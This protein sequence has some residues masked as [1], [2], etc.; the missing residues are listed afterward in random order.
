MTEQ[1]VGVATV[2]PTYAMTSVV[3]MSDWRSGG[4]FD[5]SMTVRSAH[6]IKGAFDLDALRV[7]LNDLVERHDAL[8]AVLVRS[9]VEI[10]LGEGVSGSIEPEVRDIAADAADRD[11]AATAF[12]AEAAA[13]GVAAEA[14]PPLR[15]LVGRLSDD[16]AV[17]VLVTHHLWSDAWSMR[18]LVRDL[19]ACYQART[20]GEA[21]PAHTAMSYREVAVDDHSEAWQDQSR[22]RQ[23]YWAQRLADFDSPFTRRIPV[24][25][26]GAVRMNEQYA[27]EL[28]EELLEQLL[29]GSRRRRTTPFVTALTA[30]LLWLYRETGAVDLSVPT[31]TAGRTPQEYSTVGLFINALVMRADLADGPTVAE[32]Q[33]RVH[34]ICLDAYLHEVP[35][36][37]LL[38][39]VPR[40]GELLARPE[41]AFPVFQLIQFPPDSGST[42]SWGPG[43]SVTPMPLPGDVGQVIPLEYLCTLELTDRLVYRVFH[44]PALYD[45]EEVRQHVIDFERILTRVCTEPDTRIEEIVR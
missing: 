44:D 5:P 33:A 30:Y 25:S 22:E 14:L 18:I 4:A 36:F 45:A 11:A 23:P 2:A 32:L 1:D 3:M 21:P 24:E 27:V 42:S 12:V 8:R 6:R 40:L 19:A 15:A 10:E 26:V 34:K 7:A 9:G 20:A 17:L 37:R 28:P 39:A 41:V 35:L 16:D 43:V 29:T 38:E 13:V 31:I